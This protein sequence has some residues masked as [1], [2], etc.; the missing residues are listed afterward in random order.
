MKTKILV[1][2]MFFTIIQICAYGQIKVKTTDGGS[3]VTRLGLGVKVNNGSTLNRQWI[4]INDEKSPLKLQDVGIKVTYSSPSFSFASAGFI[5]PHDSIVAYE[6]HH[7]LYDFFGEHIKT[8]S[9]LQ[10]TDLL[11]PTDIGG[12]G[13]SSSWY[14][15]E[16]DVSEYFICVSYVAKVRT[17]GSQIWS[18]DLKTIQNELQK[19]KLKFDESYEPKP[20]QDKK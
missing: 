17:K 18:Y 6:I 16:N 5:Y 8:L 19:I 12:I 2:L 13:S 20:T 9:N 10:I 11:V 4:T 7:V 14:A 15:S 1:A 3:V